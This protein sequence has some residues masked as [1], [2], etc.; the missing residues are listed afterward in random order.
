MKVQLDYVS[1]EDCE[2]SFASDLKGR[3]LPQGLIPNLLCAGVM[4]GGKDTCQVINHICYED[5]GR[6]DVFMTLLAG[7]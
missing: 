3:Q 4:E 1:E 6:R 2:K 7:R 5:Q